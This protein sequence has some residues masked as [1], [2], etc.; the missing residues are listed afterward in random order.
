MCALDAG[1]VQALDYAAGASG[2]SSGGGG[3][4][5]GA[6]DGATDDQILL[7]L[8]RA[9]HDLILSSAAHGGVHARLAD[10]GVDRG[11]Q[12]LGNVGARSAVF[13]LDLVDGDRIDRQ[14]CDRAVSGCRSDSGASNVSSKLGGAQRASFGID[15]L[16]DGNGLACVGADLEQLA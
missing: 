10:L 14:T 2:R 4:Q 12:R 15:S 3:S 6:G 9:E 1:D 11:G 7:G 8:D 5:A 13:I 16:V